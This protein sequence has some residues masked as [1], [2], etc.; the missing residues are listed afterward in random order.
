MSRTQLAFNSGDLAFQE[1]ITSR[2]YPD[3]DRPIAPFGYFRLARHS[4]TILRG[5]ANRLRKG[6]SRVPTKRLCRML[7][8]PCHSPPGILSKGA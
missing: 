3:S 1:I 6:A 8:W 4:G 7:I 2:P 5:I